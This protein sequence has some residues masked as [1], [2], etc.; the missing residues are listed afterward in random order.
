MTTY[1]TDAN[2]NPD[3]YTPRLYP[4]CVGCEAELTAAEYDDYLMRRSGWVLCFECRERICPQ[5]KDGLAEEAGKIC[6]VCAEEV[7]E[8]ERNTA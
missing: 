3:A 5:C 7:E 2:G 1:F 4:A 6:G 8:G